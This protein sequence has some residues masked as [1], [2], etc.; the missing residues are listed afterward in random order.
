[1][2]E[3]SEEEGACWPVGSGASE[4]ALDGVEAQPTRISSESRRAE[5]GMNEGTRGLQK[6]DK[7]PTLSDR[8][9]MRNEE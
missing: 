3:A 1:M 2:G 4:G 9:L 7:G 5:R 8:T 6:S